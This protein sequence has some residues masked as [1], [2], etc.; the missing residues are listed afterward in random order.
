MARHRSRSVTSPQ[1]PPLLIRL[2]QA[3][4][5]SGQL[6]LADALH[7][8]G[9]FALVSIPTRGLFVP[10]DPQFL[11]SIEAVAKS[12][13]GVTAP[14]E[15]FQRAIAVVENWDQRNAIES[16][17]NHVRDVAE[18]AYFYAGLVFGVTFADFS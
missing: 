4:R 15:S 1:L 12:H 10:E 3:A 17:F 6:N 13:L 7:E 2:I 9:T 16:A 14:L 11:V 5:D 8:F 18:D